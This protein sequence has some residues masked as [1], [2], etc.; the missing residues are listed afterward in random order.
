M[1]TS[2]SEMKNTLES[3]N[4]SLMEAEEQISKVEDRVVES[5]PQK[6]MKRKE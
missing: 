6:R 1:N 5:M 4:S 2:I 3:F